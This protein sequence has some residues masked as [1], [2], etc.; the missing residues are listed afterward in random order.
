[1]TKKKVRQ[2]YF[3]KRDEDLWQVIE[4]IPDGDKN[5]EI[6][7]A[8]RAYFLDEPTQKLQ[9]VKKIEEPEEIKIEVVEK[10]KENLFG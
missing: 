2:F 7:K 1:M 3:T 10:V 9:T 4:N 5:H 6:R 8:L